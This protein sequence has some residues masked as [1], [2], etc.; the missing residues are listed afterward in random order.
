MIILLKILSEKQWYL[1]NVFMLMSIVLMINKKYLILLLTTKQKLTLRFGIRH[2]LYRSHENVITKEKFFQKWKKVW[3]NLSLSTPGSYVLLA[4][5]CFNVDVLIY[6][7]YKS[8]HAY[9]ESFPKFPS[10]FV[11]QEGFSWDFCHRIQ[12]ENGDGT[13]NTSWYETVDI[14]TTCKTNKCC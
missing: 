2:L 4:T 14:Q 8:L 1:G 12:I 7:Y 6:R 10:V 11:L 3:T 9:I 13:W 5:A